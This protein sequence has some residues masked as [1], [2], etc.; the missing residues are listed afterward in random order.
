SSFHSAEPPERQS[1]SP[2][3][4]FSWTTGLTARLPPSVPA[5][6]P[7]SVPASLPPSVPASVPTLPEPD[8]EA[9]GPP[10]GPVRAEP[11]PRSSH[12]PARP[13]PA[14]SLIDPSAAGGRWL[15]G[16]SL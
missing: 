6:L 2:G 14:Q 10:G 9:S 13:E 15:V 16:R 1:G 12:T 8:P 3:N 11:Q 5:S 7:P 4:A